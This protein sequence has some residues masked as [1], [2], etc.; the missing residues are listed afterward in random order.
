MLIGYKNNG[1][2]ENLIYSFSDRNI[3]SWE[4]SKPTGFR[5]PEMPRHFR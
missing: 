4:A 1:F 2:D 3:D 5:A